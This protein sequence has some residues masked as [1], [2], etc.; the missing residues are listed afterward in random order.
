MEPQSEPVDDEPIVYRAEHPWIFGV[1]GRGTTLLAG[2]PFAF[3]VDTR[4]IVR[5]HLPRGGHSGGDHRPVDPR[6]TDD[7]AVRPAAP[8]VP[9]DRHG[10]PVECYQEYVTDGWGN[11]I[12]TSPVYNVSHTHVDSFGNVTAHVYPRRDGTDLPPVNVEPEQPVYHKPER[13]PNG[14]SIV[15]P[16]YD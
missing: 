7:V 15:H 9:P 4:E 2:D 11:L 16:D 10:P 8:P 5:V 12:Y 13:I 6:T 1:V 14:W 3:N